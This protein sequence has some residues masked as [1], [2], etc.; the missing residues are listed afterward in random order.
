MTKTELL[1]LAAAANIVG[2]HDMTKAQLEAALDFGTEVP[3]LAA[4]ET[5][6]FD[7]VTSTETT[8]AKAPRRV[9]TGNSG[10]LPYQPKQYALREIN[11]DKAP[12]QIRG[13][14]AFMQ[15]HALLEINGRSLSGPA[16]A[17]GAVDEGYLVTKSDPAVIFAYYARE[18][19]R[20]GM[21]FVGYDYD[22]LDL[23]DDMDD[24]EDYDV[25]A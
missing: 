18:M 13:I 14:F 21:V 24:E 3:E 23:E 12:K 10:N 7:A 19:E 5:A 8:P 1:K 11:L 25:A 4:I 16:I 20:R 9:R 22:H 6:I 17:Q 15:K 2:R